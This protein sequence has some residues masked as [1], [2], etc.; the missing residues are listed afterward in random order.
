MERLTTDIIFEEDQSLLQEMKQNLLSCPSALK[1]IRSLGIP[2]DKIDEYIVKIN[3]FVMD[4]Q[5]CKKCPGLNRCNKS[6]PRLV[7][8][9]VYKNGIVSRELVPCKEYLKAVKF[10]GEFTIRDFDDSWLESDLK[11]MDKNKDRREVVEK[12]LKYTLGESDEWLFICGEPG[13]GRSFLAA[14]IAIDIAK[15]EKG[16]VAFLDVPTRFKEL[17][18]TKDNELFNQIIDKYIK[19]PVLVLDDL[20]NEYK[21]DFVRESILFPIINGRAKNHLL[22]IITSDFNINDIAT[23]YLTGP[24]S[25][26]KVEQIKRLLKRVCGKELM[27]ALAAY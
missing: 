26:P 14:T 4:T 10:R 11:T 27:Q 25:K 8:K 7:T 21:S 2:E 18:S 3:D 15:K 13:S 19:V 9:I 5:F 24:A 16:P 6:T 20:G 12:Y 1:Y 23:M 22:T 17:A